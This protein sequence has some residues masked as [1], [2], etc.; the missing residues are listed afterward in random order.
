MPRSAAVHGVERRGSLC[1][2]T[3]AFRD[4]LRTHPHAA[5]RCADVEREAAAQAPGLLAY[6]ALKARTVARIMSAAREG[7]RPQRR[8][9][10]GATPPDPGKDT[11]ARA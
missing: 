8:P 10:G 3:I 2:D 4:D 1:A 7:G 6:S 11:G 9:F 5:D